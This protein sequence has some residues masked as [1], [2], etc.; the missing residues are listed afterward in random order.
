MVK[1][2][3]LPMKPSICRLHYI[4]LKCVA[5]LLLASCAHEKTYR[6]G[7]SQCSDDDWRQKM[8]EE[9]LR[10]VMFHDNVEIEIRSADDD[11]RRQ[12]ADIEYFAENGFDI[13]IAAPNEAG[14]LTPVIKKVYESGLPIIVF[15]RTINGDTYTA[16]QGADNVEIGRLAAQLANSMTAGRCRA[17]EIYGLDGSTPA[18]ERQRGFDSEAERLGIEILGAGYGNWNSDDGA[19]AA[20]SLL[21]LYPE[22]NL[23]FAHNDRMA[24]AASEVA[25]KLGRRDRITIIGVDAAPTIGIKAVSDS[26]I[27][28]TFLY[29][30]E[31][32]RIIRTALD[33]LEG[34]EVERNVKLPTPAAVDT[35]HAEMLLLLDKAMRAETEKVVE[36]KARLDSYW[37]QHSMQTAVLYGAIIIVVLL[38][39]VVF[40]ILRRFWDNNRHRREIERRN[41]EIERNNR[42][43]A[44]QRDELND[45]YVK[46]QDATVSKLT[47]FT[48]VSHDLRT[49]LTL[50]AD[51]VE[52]LAE[53]KNLTSQQHT[54]MQLAKK[55]VK[56]L[57]RL[58]NQILDIRKSDNG[59]LRLNLSSV[60]M[61]DAVAEWSEAFRN[62]ARK[63]CIRFAIDISRPADYVTTVDVEKIERVFF[64][65]LSNAFKFTPENGS[66]N[67]AMRSDGGNIVLTVSDTGYGMSADEMKQVFDRF[68]HTDRINPNGSGIGLALTK[69]F[70]EMHSGSIAVESEQGKGTVFTVTL[71]VNKTEAPAADLQPSV[72]VSQSDVAELENVADDGAEVSPDSPTVLV[73]DDNPD[74]CVLVKTVLGEKYTVVSAR[75]GAAGIRLASKYIPD[76]II[77]DVMM[78]G[79]DG[80]ETCRRLKGEVATS[81]IPVLQLTACSRDDQRT[82]AYESGAD[83]Y[84]SKPFDSRML[85]ARCESLI[86]NRRLICQSDSSTVAIRS[87]ASSDSRQHGQPSEI[88]SRFYRRFV[89]IVE[90]NIS[91]SSLSVE[92]IA[93][94]IGMSRVQMYR[95]I[96][97]ITNYSP[98]ELIRNIR[99][100][101]AS[102]MLKTTETTVSEVAYAVGFST[103]GYFT[104]CYKERYGESPTDTQS[105][106]SK[107]S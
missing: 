66:I 61:A 75:S 69:A 35:P 53:A 47:F 12:I 93:D 7:V 13:I 33:V 77:C 14:S 91:D 26:V 83:G 40:L 105:R 89:E 85:L 60:D 34:R 27:D 30:T 74:I 38:A 29:P 63:R 96:K 64:N 76:L 90:G 37:K 23:I 46:L 59:H 95:K 62:A 31:G 48:N 10:E 11:S 18:E 103:P 28:A 21:R 15:D 84:L 24:I 1:P 67:I 56:I 39:G 98:V 88:D 45:L 72:E 57:I 5:L 17:I 100:A 94:R 106:T 55:N 20:D 32:H 16:F 8:N 52:Q 102:R 49:P 92:E 54:L 65:M 104:K 25:K 81:H 79:M 86:R 97:A 50:I 70:V 78:P 82:E 41:E 42:E 36:L 99:L 73:I 43:L 4:I 22:A 9:M 101:K 3:F 71:P 68:F 51:P 80:Y 44:S 19:S 2:I 87:D 58:V 6:I 107:S